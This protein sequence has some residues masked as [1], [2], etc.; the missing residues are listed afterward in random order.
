MIF[1]A[2]YK[3]NIQFSVADLL[4]FFT[5]VISKLAFHRGVDITRYSRK[6]L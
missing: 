4:F 6:F 5:E 2:K 1:K 3:L